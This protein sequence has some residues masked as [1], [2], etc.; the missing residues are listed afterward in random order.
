MEAV[1]L[2]KYGDASVRTVLVDGEPWFVGKDVAEV[3]GYANT[4]DAIGAHVDDDDKRVIQRS[5]STTFEIPNRGL[6][7]INESGLYSL[8]LGSKLPDAKKFKR[9]VTS[10]VL[11]ALRKHGAYASEEVID[12][13][14][15]DPDFAIR[16]FTELKEEKAKR[17]ELESTVAIQEKLLEE[18]KPKVEFCDD[19]LRSPET[20]TVTFIAKEYGLA[21]HELNEFLH[22]KR[23]QYKQ[24][25][26]WFLYQK[27]AGEGY[28]ASRTHRNIGD[29][30]R[31]HSYVS[32]RW[33]QKGRMFVHTLLEKNGI[34]PKPESDQI[35]MS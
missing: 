29:D 9:W 13:I 30:G 1:Q 8:I 34:F 15:G 14:L 20:V 6:T 18:A 35:K 17:R 25:K 4:K 26:L 2:F 32:M 16:L 11:P 21:P 19:V 7:V 5:E 31:M 3:L 27:Y 33:T 24:G 12:K 22:E 28:M 10:E 23:I